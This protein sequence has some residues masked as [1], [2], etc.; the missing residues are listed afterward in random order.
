MF[1]IRESNFIRDGFS[2]GGSHPS[3]TIPNKTQD[4][5]EATTILKPSNAI[6]LNS[7]NRIE[8]R[9]E[10]TDAQR[11]GLTM[12]STE[13]SREQKLMFD[14]IFNGIGNTFVCFM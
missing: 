2:V 3:S 1:E 12:S 7:F 6:V 10:A 4:M 13:E 11:K 14:V 9:T 5:Y 8:N